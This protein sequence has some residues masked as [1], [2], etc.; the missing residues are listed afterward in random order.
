MDFAA[1]LVERLHIPDDMDHTVYPAIIL[2]HIVRF[3]HG[4]WVPY[5]EV[6]KNV[7]SYQELLVNY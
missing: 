7:S 6:H 4:K 2:F 1:E 5:T 3:N